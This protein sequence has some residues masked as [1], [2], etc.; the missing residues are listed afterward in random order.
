M[1]ALVVHVSAST[2]YATLMAPGYWGTEAACDEALDKA[3]SR[4]DEL[5]AV[6]AQCFH[7]KIPG[8]N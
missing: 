4:R 7:I 8:E 2:G 3:W 1:L 5:Q 6:A